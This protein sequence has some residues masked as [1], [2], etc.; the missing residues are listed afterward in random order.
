MPLLHTP[1]EAR[2]WGH[3]SRTG[4][5]GKA[6]LGMLWQVLRASE[7]CTLSA[8]RGLP[9]RAEV[10]SLFNPVQGPLSVGPQAP[11]PPVQQPQGLVRVPPGL[12]LELTPSPRKKVSQRTLRVKCGIFMPKAWTSWCE[13]PQCS[14]GVLCVAASRSLVSEPTGDAETQGPAL[15]DWEAGKE[16]LPPRNEPGSVLAE[17]LLGRGA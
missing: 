12:G 9:Q 2:S 6:H 8:V 4:C 16:G 14:V 10:L 1:H 5:W 7:S 11:P 17:G 15:A 13:G 3:L